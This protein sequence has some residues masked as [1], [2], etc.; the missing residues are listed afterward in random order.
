MLSELR[1]T[2]EGVGIEGVVHSAGIIRDSLIRG[3]GAAAG[4]YDVWSSKARSAWYLHELTKSDNLS[5]FVCY[6]SIVGSIGNIGQSAY[7]AANRFLD[8]LI[9]HRNRNGFA[10]LSASI[11]WPAIRGVGMAAAAESSGHMSL[12]GCSIGEREFNRVLANLLDNSHRAS[13]LPLESLRFF[14]CLYWVN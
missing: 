4:S 6:S 2:Y 12:E 8:G 5:L 3:G 10:C 1:S 7:C 11:R 14:R 13:V 9:E